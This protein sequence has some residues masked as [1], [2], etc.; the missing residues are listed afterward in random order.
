[1]LNGLYIILS[2]L[3]LCV[4]IIVHEFGHY[5]V[6]RL[7]GIGILEFSVGFGP[8]LF[9][10]TRKGIDYSVRALPLGGYCKFLGED[11]ENSAPNAM[12]NA[13]VW[14]RIAT[15]AAGPAMNF[16]LA[17]I[18]AVV[19]LCLFAFGTTT[20]MISEVYDNTPA[21]EAGL[22]AG[23][24]IVAANG[25]EISND[26][27]GVS[28]VRQLITSADGAVTLTVDRGGEEIS[29][30]LTPALVTDE[31]TG[32]TKK[33][34]GIVFD[35]QWETYSFLEAIP[36]AGRYMIEYTKELLDFLRKLIFKFEGA[37]NVSGV[38]GTVAVMSDTMKSDPLLVWEILFLISLNLGI[39]N[40]LP[41][42]GLDG[43]RLVFLIIEA[44]RG[45]PV[46]PD[47][48]G[49]V[50]FI[51]LALLMLLAVVL[52]WHDIVTYIF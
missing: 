51:G 10:W 38:V 2:L 29:F 22:M 9:G 12:N 18:S 50:H 26:N 49:L 23:D 1:M 41:I 42:P 4:I 11:S 8:K 34:I 24:V 19:M 15:V 16:V 33:Q 36:G 39:M 40:L 21:A 43:G 32:E 13:S 47:K 44:V 14:K 3:V 27:T 35:T 20:A 46:P 6:G 5:L 48:E 52:V 25:T 31:T 17:Y 37:E 30:D 7:C 28:E 45:K